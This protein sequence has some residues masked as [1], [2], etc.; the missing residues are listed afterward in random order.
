[1]T[2]DS[3]GTEQGQEMSCYEHMGIS[4]FLIRIEFDA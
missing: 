3:A 4:M 1:M 2:W